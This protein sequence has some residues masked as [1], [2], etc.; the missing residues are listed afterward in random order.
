MGGA[1]QV[2]VFDLHGRLIRS[3]V[4]ESLLAG[5]HEVTWNGRDALGRPVASGVYFVRLLSPDGSEL[6]RK[7]VLAK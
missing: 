5:D 7:L 2:G 1:T 4:R 3:L 6:S